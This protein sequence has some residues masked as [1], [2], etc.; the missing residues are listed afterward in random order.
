MQNLELEV[1]T[2]SYDR[3]ICVGVCG[4][5]TREMGPQAISEKEHRH[6]HRTREDIRQHEYT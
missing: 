4:P 3:V 1:D 2:S 6:I 5:L